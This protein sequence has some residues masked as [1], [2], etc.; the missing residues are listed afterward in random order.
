ME[1]IPS[2][3]EEHHIPEDL[4]REKMQRCKLSAVP[5]HYAAG[6]GRKLN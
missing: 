4:K 5:K 1:T 3:I 6:H 2:R